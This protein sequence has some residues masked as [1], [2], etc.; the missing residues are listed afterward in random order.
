MVLLLFFT[1][2][3]TEKKEVKDGNENQ[4]VVVSDSLPWSERMALSIME[5]D[6]KAWQ[7]ENDSIPKWNYKIG[8][9]C[10]AFQQLYKRTLDERFLNYVKDYTDVIINDEGVITG[11]NLEEYNIDM[12]N[13]GK[14]LFWLYDETQDPKYHKALI[15]LRKQLDGHPRTN[16]HGFWHKKIYPYQM[17][18]DGLYMGTPF[19]AEYNTRFENGD[20]LDDIAHQFELIWKHTFDDETGLLYH[21]WDESKQMDWANKENGKSPNFWSRSM[22]WYVM[23]LV[24]VL[25]FFPAEHPKREVLVEQLNRLSEALLEHQDETGLWYQVPNMPEKEGNYLESSG[26]SMFAYGFAKG[27]SK[28]YLPEEYLAH[29]E[30]IFNGLVEHLIKVDANGEV[31]ITQVCKSAGLG[32]NPYRDGSFEYYISEPIVTDNLHGLGPFILAANQ[33][34]K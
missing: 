10:T 2:C 19:Y 27:T 21:A 23:A 6:P 4:T 26:S 32:G 15:E 1:G 29:A 16:S 34:N 24:D 3:K 20:K 7:T 9:L 33:L 17:W 11:Y 18:L 22:G 14:M 12:I 28:G 30:K 25:D 8:L 31:H 5:R 13:S